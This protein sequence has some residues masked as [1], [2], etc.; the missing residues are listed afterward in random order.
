MNPIDILLTGLI[1]VCIPLVVQR[2]LSGP[3]FSPK[4]RSMIV[5]GGWLW[6]LYALFH[7][8]ISGY[9][10]GIWYTDEIQH[11]IMARSLMERMAQG[12][13][14]EVWSRAGFGNDA[15]QL[16]LALLYYYTGLSNNGATCINMFFAFWGGLILV[17]QVVEILPPSAPRSAWP[18]LIIFFPSVVYW[19]TWNL[20]EG[21]M[22]FA[23]CLVF[24][25]VRSRPLTPGDLA[26]VTT[27][28]LI[29]MCLR[30]HIITGWGLAVLGVNLVTKGRKLLVLLVLVVSPLLI[31]AFSQVTQIKTPSTGALLER[32]YLQAHNISADQR[33]SD[34]D[35]GPGGPI[36]FVSGFESLF[37]RPYPWRAK[38]L[39]L[40]LSSIETWTMTLFIIWVWVKMPIRQ[41]LFFLKMPHI[42]MAI[43]ACIFFSLFFTF[44]SN[45]GLMVRQ[46]VQAVPALMVLGFVPYLYTRAVK[47]W[48]RT[49]WMLVSRALMNDGTQQASGR[50][51]TTV[52]PASFH[53][54]RGA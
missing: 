3:A 7:V 42:R 23:I 46:R 39:R 1:A 26:R 31:V 18:L 10:F 22:Y 11:N 19:C 47:T 24:S 2:T 15:W 5:I 53:P 54:H 50:Q 40:L 38:S 33:G 41:I 25:G 16:Y 17:R 21:F 14:D 12:R 48:Q 27:G 36:L 30:A 13:W 49:Q 43:L 8:F 44:L 35:F 4:L 34:I 32:A 20:K 9:L 28:L 37:F 52:G 51:Q 29:G 6:L 45:E